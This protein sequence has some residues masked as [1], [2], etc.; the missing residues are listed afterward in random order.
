MCFNQII[1]K[2]CVLHWYRYLQPIMFNVEDNSQTTIHQTALACQ[3]P[4]NRD[5]FLDLMARE[6]QL[7]STRCVVDTPPTPDNLPTPITSLYTSPVFVAISLSFSPRAVL[8]PL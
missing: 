8:S 7:S 5:M 3:A 1:A 6:P 2:Q 4:L